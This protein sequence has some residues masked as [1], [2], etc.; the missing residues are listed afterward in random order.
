MSRRAPSGR[1]RVAL[2]M[3]LGA[4]AFVAGTLAAGAS[5]SPLERALDY[6]SARQDPATGAVG[7]EA[8]RAADTAWTAMAVAGAG[9]APAGW[10][11]G[12]ATLASA[13]GALP[14]DATGDLLRLAVARRAAGLVDA[15]LAARVGAQQSA[16]G[17]FPGGPIATSWG[18]LALR[19]TGRAPGDAA[20]TAA[21]GALAAQRAAD[22]GW[23]TTSGAPASDAVATATA[24]QALRAARM[25]VTDPV[26]QG[27]RARLLALRDPDGGF[28][29]SPV[30]TAWAIMAIRSLGERPGRGP[31]ARG[32]SPITVLQGFQQ[33]DGGIRATPSS[34]ASVF[35]T[36]VAA[37]AWSRGLLPVA[38]GTARTPDRAPRV[39]RRTPATGDVVRGVLSVRYV[40]ERGGT[41][42]D[43]LRTTV[44]VNGADITRS[45]RITPFT[46]QLRQSALPVGSL[47][48]S[49][50][51][52]DRAGHGTRSEWTVV[53]TG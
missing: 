16:D 1:P 13:V 44:S 10:V 47:A 52:R 30:P 9:E 46:L 6:L 24:I 50:M 35:S 23:S 3:A 2:A 29:R 53:G 25:P 48:V 49:V 11:Q 18:I 39:V 42:I 7:P 12:T 34:G 8:G 21:V 22:G 43:P 17:S 27:A 33:D 32:G 26:L 5:A 14:M 40:D 15:D 31:W 38:P 51:V 20:L 37:L 45:A 28:A 41:G 4:C 36:A 19:A